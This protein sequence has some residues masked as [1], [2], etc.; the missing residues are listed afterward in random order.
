MR[1]E[2]AD[3]RRQAIQSHDLAPWVSVWVVKLDEL[4]P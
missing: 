2:L 3:L 1:S 4:D